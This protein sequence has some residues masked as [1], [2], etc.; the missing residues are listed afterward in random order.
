MIF[1]HNAQQQQQAIDSK[2]SYQNAMW[3]YNDNRPITTEIA[4]EKKFYFAEEHHQQYL[5]KNPDGYCGLGGIEVC[6][7]EDEKGR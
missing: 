2:E 5:A 1:T 3:A 6:L 7:P 4:V